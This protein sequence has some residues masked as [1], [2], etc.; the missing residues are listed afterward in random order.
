MAEETRPYRHLNSDGVWPG[1]SWHGLELTPDGALRLMGVPRFDGVVPASV[2]QLASIQTPAGIAIDRAG[3]VFYSDPA[4]AT[5]Y[6]ID[7]CSHETGAAPCLGGTGGEPTQFSQP[8]GLLI[9]EHR[10]VLYVADS[11]NHRI[12]LFDLD[13]MALVEILTGFDRPVSLA[14][15]ADGNLYV[16]DTGTQRVDKLTLSADPVPS[17]WDS[18]HASGRVI[19]PRAVACEGESV[20]VLDGQTHNVCV[21]DRQGGLADEV[22]T[23]VDSAEVFAVDH[24]TIY[25]GDIDRRR[26]A[27]FRKNQQGVYVVVGDAAGYDGPVAALAPDHSGGLLLLAGSGVAPLHLTVDAGH[28]QDGWVWS[29][30]IAFDD[31]EHFWNRLHARID[32]PPSTHVQ[33]FVYR[34]KGS[35][36]PPPPTASGA[37][38]PPW[39]AIGNDV[40]DFFLTFDTRKTQALWVGAH[41]SNDS[42]A[43]PALSQLRI[44]FDQDS[45][46]SYLPAIYREPGCNDF[47]LRYVSLFES[48]FDELETKIHGLPV[49]LD[50][51]AAPDEALPWLAG[52]LALALPETSSETDQRDAIAGAYARYA[53]RGTV[54]GLRETLHAEAGVR[55]SIDE[56]LQ[57]MGLWSLPA[58][59][60]SCKPD[61]AGEWI[62]GGGAVLGLTTILASGEAQGAV[63]GATAVLDHSQ[64][65][66]QEEYG[67]PMFEDL[68]YRFTVQVYA[69]E[70]SCPAKLDQVKAILDREK[71]A[72]TMYDVCVIAP[73]VRIGYQA[74]LGIDTVLGG[75]SVPGRLGETAL[76]LS[77]QH[78]AQVGTRSLVGVS[79][80]L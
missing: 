31:L 49:L 53:R 17:F 4:S 14:S 71:P 33:F 65:I 29:G 21:F 74:R 70:L 38:D 32:L 19:D 63:V 77:G 69:G 11:G 41:F 75:E 12:Q 25:V 60:T 18:V 26:L 64:L 55:A 22:E 46:L 62:D 9:P 24:G 68:A 13:T 20:Y 66:T 7:G 1:F 42:H 43:T 76:V 8:S 47:L 78:R 56:P 40:S 3:T 39:H 58:P 2:S 45:Y 59:S 27:V 73:G 28:R 34:D 50:P 54:E 72:H 15:D 80:Q 48:F 30:A 23:Q 37:F 51:A 57:A 6:R 44:D 36:P 35:V 61:V 16:V 67:T 79:T 5:V 10:H 52:F